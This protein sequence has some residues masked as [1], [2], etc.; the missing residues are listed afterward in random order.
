MDVLLL[1]MI[2][3]RC[4]QG[5]N[6]AVSRIAIA[7]VA[8][9][10]AACERL[11]ECQCASWAAQSQRWTMYESLPKAKALYVDACW[12]AMDARRGSAVCWCNQSIYVLNLLCLL[13]HCGVGWHRCCMVTLRMCV[14]ELLQIEKLV[15]LVKSKQYVHTKRNLNNWVAIGAVLN[16]SRNTCQNKYRHFLDKQFCR[17]KI[18][19]TSMKP[20][21]W[22]L[23]II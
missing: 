19:S 22:A 16:R 8:T 9:S 21:L 11:A 15:A 6:G 23:L 3:E 2:V 13:L 20:D 18:A 1:C 12:A 17:G 4:S 5:S 10:C 14:T 7:A